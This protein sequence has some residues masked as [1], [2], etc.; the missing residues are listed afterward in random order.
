MKT[1]AIVVGVSDYHDP[2][3]E[4][5]PGAQADARRFSWAL[6]SWGIPK[7]WI[8]FITNEKAT[9]A[10][11]IKTFYDCRSGFDTDAKLIFY[12]AGHGVR[13]TDSNQGMPE[14]SL[15]LYDT[16]YEHPLS[17]GLRLVE[18]MQLIRALK[19]TQVFLFIDACSLRLNQI[20]NPLNDEEILSTTASKGLFCML[21]SGINKSYEDAILHYGYFTHALLKAISEL[22]TH[23]Q[24][25]CHDIVKKVSAALKKQSLPPPEVYLIGSENMWILESSYQKEQVPLRNSDELVLREETLAKLQDLIVTHPDPIVWMWGEGG[26]GKTVI[27]EQLSQKI[28]SSLYVSIPKSSNSSIVILRSLIEQMR[29]QKSELFF[30]RP[31][32]NTISQT[33][34][35]IYSQTPDTI[36]ILDH[37]DRLNSQDVLTIVSEID[38][39][40]LPCI[41]ISRH[42][43]PE[44]SFKLRRSNVLHWRAAPLNRDEAIHLLMKSGFDPSVAHMLL[45]ATSGNALKVRQMLLKLSGQD[46]PAHS[47]AS[48]ELIHC[49]TSVVA[50]GGFL[51]EL[52]FCETFDLQLETLLT[53]EKLGL[54]RFTT[55]GCYPHD[56]LLDIVDENKWSLDLTKACEY[57]NLQILQTPYNLW[58]C[59]SLVLLAIHIND[60]TPFKQ[61]LSLCLETLTERENLNYMIDL[62]HIFQK[63]AWDELLLKTTDYLIDY[64]AYQLA[65]EMLSR[66]LD[67]KIPHIKNHAKK[68]D[69]RRYMLLGYLNECIQIYTPFLRKCRSSDIAISIRNSLGLSHYLL[70][71]MDTA[72]SYFEENLKVTNT[73]NEM[74]QGIAKLLMGFLLVYRGGDIS[75]AKIM[76][77]RGLQV[78]ES[79]NS[80]TWMILA[81]IGLS[82][83]AFRQKRWQQAIL[84]L[85]KGLE[86]A[87][88]L[89]HKAFILFTYSN[90]SK[91]YVKLYHIASPE[92]SQAVDRMESVLKQI[93]E[94]GNNWVIL[95]IQNALALIYARR[96][97]IQKLQSVLDRISSQSSS[98]KWPYIYTLANK[99][100]LLA[101]KGDY[102]KAKQFYQ[103][104][105]SLAQQL[106]APLMHEEIILDLSWC[107]LPSPMVEKIIAEHQFKSVK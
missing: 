59:R 63:Q 107:A 80:Y 90:L 94:Y 17:T 14:S 5:I 51:N 82:D 76:F 79:T 103:N 104:S 54:I 97:E 18:L 84:Y 88:A 20:D 52:L 77:D 15:I 70:G 34:N 39:V 28:S 58:A 32:E 60:N 53:L 49:I 91:N 8:Y 95:W 25:N 106:Y 98:N 27:A 78:F 36:L 66:L 87:E 75:E 72:K 9:K 26:M 29:S 33:L 13:E 12:F 85:N 42:P 16:R 57:W 69:A 100:H 47:H 105:L 68:N 2:L 74:E 35:Y 43:C 99:G 89:E 37:L 67:S 24:T 40:P 46:I 45:H 23:K 7:E 61:A 101:L 62:A 73:R 44:H 10:N 71:N 50:C 4:H 3:F 102:E 30:N 41:L 81:F 96:A 86:I 48:V 56:V 21:S 6:T 1:I 31:P 65:G 38:Q 93:Q 19:P 83:H 22:R 92:I 64:E 11:I 55:Q